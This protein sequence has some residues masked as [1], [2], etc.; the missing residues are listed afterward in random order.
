[1]PIGATALLL[2]PRIVPES[3]LVGARRRFDPLGALTVTGALLLLVYTISEA[4]DV[5]W[6][7][8]RTVALLAASA[9]LLIAFLVVESR[10]ESPLLPLRILRLRT[11]AAANAVGLLISGSF[12]GFIFIGTLYM[13][14]V[15]GYSALQAGG[16]WLATTLTT[17]ALA[18]LSQRLVTRIS[19]G[20]VLAVGVARA[21]AFS[22]RLRRLCTGTFGAR[23]PARSSAPAPAPPSASSRS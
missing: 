12:F 17:L 3:R 18:P 10:V 6:S 4:P 23:W 14:Q 7:T 21:A 16:A 11:V 5:G 8:A 2:A 1:V 15:L 22:G 20:P 19:L 9:V 13:Q